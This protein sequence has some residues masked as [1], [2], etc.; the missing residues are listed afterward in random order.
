[1][2]VS[3][4]TPTPLIGALLIAEGLVSAAQLTGCLQYQASERPHMPLGQIL[5]AQ[6]HISQAD[7]AASE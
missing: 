7:L 5:F 2:A 3:S 6:G 4:D 1:M